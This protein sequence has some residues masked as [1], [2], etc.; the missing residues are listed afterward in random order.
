MSECGDY[1]R[2]ELEFMPRQRFAFYGH[3]CEVGLFVEC[4]VNCAVCTDILFLKVSFV[5]VVDRC[6][7]VI[8]SR[9]AALLVPIKRACIIC[10]C[11]I[12]VSNVTLFFSLPCHQWH[13]PLCFPV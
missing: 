12:Y 9:K 7:M 1:L 11:H 8:V 13:F 6:K 3:S 2:R 4:I 10:L 5:N